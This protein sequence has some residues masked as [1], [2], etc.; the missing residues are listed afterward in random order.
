MNAGIIILIVLLIAIIGYGV[1][2][3]FKKWF[4][5]KPSSGR[6]YDEVKDSKKKSG[7]CTGTGT[8]ASAKKSSDCSAACDAATS[9]AC[10]GYDW[11][12]TTCTLYATPP[13]DVTAGGKDKCYALSSK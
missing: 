2:A 1:A 8:T 3:Y 13:T 12:G 7:K 9:P 10:N 6:K 11:D 5:F 4:P